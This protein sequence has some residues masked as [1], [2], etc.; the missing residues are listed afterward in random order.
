VTYDPS[1]L[2]PGGPPPR[3][4]RRIALVV[5]GALVLVGVVVWLLVGG[6]GT[7]SARTRDARR[8]ATA[9]P[10]TGA[11]PD[12]NA[13]TDGGSNPQVGD[14]LIT[15]CSLAADQSRG[16]EATVAITNQSA[17]PSS[18]AVA[19]AF[20]SRDG[21][22]RYDIGSVA[23][24]GVPPGQ[25]T[26]VQAPS[27]KAELRPAVAKAGLSCSVVKVDRTAP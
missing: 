20:T 21:A 23:V 14:V 4:S 1:V 2:K 17:T 11:A 9:P 25:R 15:G 3:P 7:D 24:R 12:M 13:T 8:K 19:V 27:D 26:V 6:S 22:I 16:L 10:S 5:A 18:Y